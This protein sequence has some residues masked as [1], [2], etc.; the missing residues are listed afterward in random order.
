MI[1]VKKIEITRMNVTLN[2]GKKF[3]IS[4]GSSIEEG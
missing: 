3:Q 1:P 4:V 2:G